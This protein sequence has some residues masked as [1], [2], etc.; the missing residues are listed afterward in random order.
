MSNHT[1]IYDGNELFGF[2]NN[3]HG[4]LGLGDYDDKNVPTL[5]MTDKTI[6]KI[7]CGSYHTFIL[8]ESGRLFV[9]GSNEYGQLGLNDNVSRNVPTLLMTN[10]NIISINGITIKKIKWN[11]DKYYYLSKQ[12]QLEIKTFILVCNYYK[13][14]Y[15]ISV[16]KNM[17]YYIINLLFW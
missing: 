2:G 9:F 13:N 4:Q 16:V 17:R 11:S 8:K 12:K 6:R 5:V 15:K 10:D 1:L 3:N 14:N 7:V